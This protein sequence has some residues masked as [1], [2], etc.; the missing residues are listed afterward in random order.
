MEKIFRIVFVLIL[1]S[2]CGMEEAGPSRPKEEPDKQVKTVTLQPSSG[3]I[4]G[5]GQELKLIV[6]VLFENGESKENA[7]EFLPLEWTSDNASV[8]TVDEKGTVKAVSAGGALITVKVGTKSA[9]VKVVV[10]AT[11][12]LDPSVNRSVNPPVGSVN[13]PSPQPPPPKEPIPCKKGDSYATSVISFKKG[14]N[15]GFNEDKLPGVVLGPPKGAGLFSGNTTDVL[16]L[17]RGGE[18]VLGFDR[19]LIVDGKGPDFTVFE[20]AF[21]IAGTDDTF[22]EPGFIGVSH[23]GIDFVEFPCS[24]TGR[25]YKG[26]AGVRPVLANPDLNSI[27]PLDPSVSGGDPFDLADLGL[28]SVRFVRIRDAGVP[29]GPVGPGTAGFDL[30]AIAI[31]NGTTPP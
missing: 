23:D 21:Q 1:F 17:G 26:C 12:S 2:G 28:K 7:S 3:N 5:I 15:G 18:I 27:D 29:I 11:P 16:S 10:E 24:S 14:E 13:P 25:P 8:A 22:A 19:C 20:N 30:D 31:V 4:K 6:V 9:V